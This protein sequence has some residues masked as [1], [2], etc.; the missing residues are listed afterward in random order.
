MAMRR[1]RRPLGSR[2]L[3]LMAGDEL[4]DLPADGPGHD[5][6][7]AQAQ[8]MLE[9]PL[10]AL[11]DLDNYLFPFAPILAKRVGR[12]FTSVWASKRHAARSYLRCRPGLECR[13]SWP[14]VLV[15]GGNSGARCEGCTRGGRAD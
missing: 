13:R 2:R 15:L 10:L 1:Y 14:R 11:N 6:L 12:Q 8:D 4:P 7:T 9:V 5:E 3:P